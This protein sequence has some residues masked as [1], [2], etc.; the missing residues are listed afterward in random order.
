MGLQSHSWVSKE[1]YNCS[2]SC[3]TNTTLL[4]GQLLSSSCREGRFVRLIVQDILVKLRITDRS[5]PVHLTG[6]DG[7]VREMLSLLNCDS[8]GLRLVVLHGMGGIGKTTLA[9]VVYNEIS[10]QFEGSS[11]L[12]NVREALTGCGAMAKL[13]NKLMSDVLGVKDTRSCNFDDEVNEIIPRLRGKRMLL[14]LDDV[15]NTPQ[16]KKL[17]GNHLDWLGPGSRIIVTTRDL[18]ICNGFVHSRELY[19]YEMKK[20]DDDHA[21][22]LFSRHAFGTDGPPEDYVFLSRQAVNA[23]GNLPLALEVTGGHLCCQ[24]KELWKYTLEKLKRVPQKEV[25]EILRISYEGLDFREKE[26]FLDIACFREQMPSNFADHLWEA[27]NLYPKCGVMALINKS[28]IKVLP[29][30]QFWIH[31]QLQDMG[32]E[33]VCSEGLGSLEKCSRVWNPD[34]ALSVV[35]QKKVMNYKLGVKGFIISL[36]LVWIIISLALRPLH[37]LFTRSRIKS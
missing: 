11:F 12:S 14:I 37:S 23:T 31:D 36:N 27:R 26:I 34:H 20:M 5:L 18:S 2:V 6:M 3:F 10:S 24:S 35:L 9:S 13:Q 8:S 1:S 33:I 30:G 22:Q 29:N 21:L 32:R 25:F 7:R 28:L 19:F 4:G 16:L 15:H 17:T